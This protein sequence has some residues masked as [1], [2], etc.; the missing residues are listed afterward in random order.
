M[1][2]FLMEA[3]SPPTHQIGLGKPWIIFQKSNHVSSDL[4]NSFLSPSPSIDAL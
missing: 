1:D 2:A 4:K 3:F